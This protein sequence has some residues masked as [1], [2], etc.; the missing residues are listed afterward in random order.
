A[1][2]AHTVVLRSL[3]RQYQTCLAA[4]MAAPAAP[5]APC[6][7]PALDRD[8][9]GRPRLVCAVAVPTHYAP[10]LAP[11]F[12][13]QHGGHLSARWDPV[14]SALAELLTPVWDALAWSGHGI[15]ESGA[16]SRVHAA[17]AVGGGL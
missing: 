17:G 15:S 9:V 5:V 2:L 10:G 12:A 6:R 8:R 11:V 7:A 1:R 3:H 16:A 14:L 4:R 13:H